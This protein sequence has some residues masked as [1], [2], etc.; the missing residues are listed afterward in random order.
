MSQLNSSFPLQWL[1]HWISSFPLS[2]SLCLSLRHLLLHNC[3][4][5]FA[6]DL[7]SATSALCHS[8]FSV[9]MVAQI[10]SLLAVSVSNCHSHCTCVSV[11]TATGNGC[12]EGKSTALFSDIR[13]N[14]LLTLECV[15]VCI[16]SVS[17]LV[18]PAQWAYKAVQLISR[19]SANWLEPSSTGRSDCTQNMSWQTQISRLNLQLNEIC[20]DF[21][22]WRQFKC[23]LICGHFVDN[24]SANC[25]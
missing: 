21:Q 13:P 11:A 8:H 18:R 6:G 10:S 22:L 3:T 2:L 4:S 5:S 7:N 1:N 14:S 23:C 24:L 20:T 19:T 16:H 25:R 15:C 12:G 17:A 9:A